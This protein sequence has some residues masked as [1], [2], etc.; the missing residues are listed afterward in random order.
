ADQVLD[1][2][3]ATVAGLTAES[4][5]AENL[6]AEIKALLKVW[7]VPIEDQLRYRSILLNC[8]VETMLVSENKGRL[9]W[10][11]NTDWFFMEM[12]EHVRGL[13]PVHT[14]ESERAGLTRYVCTG[15][16]I[17]D[18]GRLQPDTDE[19]VWGPSTSRIRYRLHDA[20]RRLMLGASLQARAI[21]LEDAPEV[22]ISNEGEGWDPPGKNLWVAFSTWE[23]W[24]HEDAIV[25]SQAAARKLKC[26]E[27]LNLPPVRIPAL[28]TRVELL[29]KTDDFVAKGA[30][31]AR[32]WIDCY[33]LGLR[34]HEA[35][36]LGAT[37]GWKEIGLPGAIAPHD[38]VIQKVSRQEIQSPCWR[39]S[40]SFLLNVRSEVGIGDKL[41]TRH[42][43][44]GVVSKILADEEMPMVDGQRAEIILSPVGIARRGAMGQFREAF[45]NLSLTG[46]PDLPLA[47]KPGAIF[48]I[49]EPQNAGDPARFRVRGT[50]PDSVRGQ[51]YGEMEFWALMA[52]GEPEIAAELLSLGRSTANWMK[53]EGRIGPGTSQELAT[54]VL[55]R[56]LAMI[57]ATIKNG[58]VQQG[59]PPEAFEIPAETLTDFRVAEDLLK[60]AKEFADKGGLGIIHFKEP[61]EVKLEGYSST[62][63][64]LYVLPPWLRPAS[65]FGPHPL[66][67]AYCW[68]LSNLKQ[69]KD[70]SR[71]IEKC[72]HCAFDEKTGVGAFLRREVL[73]RRLTRSAR[74]VIVPGPD[75]KL[76]QIRIP[77]QIT[78]VLF[79]G[80]PARSREL[81]LVNRNPTLHRRGL[82][83]LRPVIDET[84][85]PVFGLP[86]GILQ[87][88]GA[89]FD[90]DQ[91]NVVALE[92][93]GALNGAE[94]LLPGSIG[95]RK[96][97]FR[98][99]APAFP[100]LHEL[101]DP[102]SEWKLAKDEE[103]TQAAWCEAYAGLLKN[104]LNAVGD[105]WQVPALK[106]SFEKDP[107][108][109]SGLTEEAWMN[110]APTEMQKVYDSVR[111]K[112][113]LGGILRRQLYLRDYTSDKEFWWTLSA[114]QAVTEKLVQSALSVKTGKGAV[115]E[116]KPQA[117]FKD[118]NRH[119]D[120]LSVFDEEDANQQKRGF[121]SEK[122]CAALQD[123]I[124]PNG[125]L[126]W[127][128][129][130]NLSTLYKVLA[131][132][133]SQPDDCTKDPRIAWFL[134]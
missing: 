98:Q 38:G 67:K 115:V 113:Q 119:K 114:L 79:A 35:K 125:L 18:Q 88:L 5:K 9:S 91:V 80:L 34:R 39:E 11:R 96:D 50:G 25:I 13:D 32:A 15:W 47:E 106:A 77:K 100:L 8:R 28:A 24:T 21:N 105:G 57:G 123:W 63:S 54:Q 92:T 31:L 48:V 101:S 112:G 62:L 111:K 7:L 26:S 3:N 108:F 22:P 37:G 81:V 14:P 109:W 56:Y 16:V 110:L 130:P 117:F 66:T 59:S 87:G 83:A 10:S 94:K 33:A 52:H 36:E 104:R 12:R 55:N 73:G 19:T 120:S 23:G 82:L 1:W 46:T 126:A 89:D 4:S 128:A 64:H 86:L 42:G 30:L 132:S 133:N 44:K 17:D 95:F 61:V 49:R 76:D 121:E 90:G 41:A 68:L 69:G 43:I 116:F 129:H 93:E 40:I 6:A 75:L 51:R 53:W 122:V 2:L 20:P 85:Q 97:P 107:D 103:M 102:V 124:E 27:N 71:P 134:A 72:F 118:P 29:V 127:L 99:E 58:Q 78:E 74:A 70:V 60:N 131:N 65:E 45:P 84:N